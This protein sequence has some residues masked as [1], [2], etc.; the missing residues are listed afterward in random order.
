[1][2]DRKDKLV[3]IDGN[4]IIHRAW[5][6][7]PQTMRNSKGELVNAVFGFASILLKVIKDLKPRYLAV[8]MDAPGKNFR[9][10]EFPEYKAQ[11]VKKPQEFYDQFD[12]IRQVV[13]AFGLPLF[14]QPGLEAD[15]LIGSLVANPAARGLERIVVTGDQDALQLVAPGVSVYALRQGIADTVTYDAAAVREKFGLNPEQLVDY[16][17][18]RGDPSDN[19]PGVPGIGEK[20]A[21]ALLQQFGSLEN[22]YQHVE[23]PA[24]PVRTRALLQEHR[25]KALLAKRLCKITT[26]APVKFHLNECEVGAYDPA[27]VIRLFSEL[28]FKSLIN[29][30]PASKHVADAQGALA[31]GNAQNDAPTKLL[32]GYRLVDDANKLDDVLSHIRRAPLIAVDTETSSLDPL[33][34][35]LVGISLAWAEGE[36]AFVLPKPELLAK[37]KPMLSDAGIPKTGHNLKFDLHS[38]ET[39]GL[40]LSGIAFDSMIASYL[41]NPGSRQHGLD[42]L[43]FSEFGF[44]MTQITDLIGSGAK[45]RSMTEVPLDQVVPY[46]CA[47]ADYSLRLFSRL[48]RELEN[49]NQLG[50]LEKIE[51]PLI[52]VLARMER[53]GIKLDTAFLKKMST[54]V[55]KQ[56]A[57][58]E[59]KIHDLAGVPFNIASPLQMKEVLF[60]KLKIST[61][62]L[63]RTK[64]GISTAAGELE[65]LADQHQIIPLIME[66]R[67]LSKLQSTYLEALPQL[68]S[69]RDQR[70]HTSFNQTIAATGRLSSSDPNLQNI[71]IRTP[72][73]SQI[74][75]AFIAE[76]GNVL[77]SAD[78]NQIELRIIASLAQDPTMIS[79]FTRGE[80][81]HTRTAAEIHDVPV[82][83]VTKELRRTAKEVNFGIIYGMG[84]VG[85]SQRQGITRDKAKTFIDTYFR[86]HPKIAAYL[87]DTKRLA[88]E[89][90]FVETIFGR[91][92]YL[93]EIASSAP[94]IRSGAERAAINHPVQGTAADLM[95][96]AMIAV[97]DRLPAVCPAARMLLQVHD[98]LVFEVPASD[99]AALAR[100][101]K[102]T[103][104]GVYQLRVPILVHVE[105]GK[106]WGDLKPVDEIKGKQ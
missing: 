99:A 1:M 65:K 105:V 37:L 8:T 89:H 27:A 42:G 15:D 103:M 43:S 9:H 19:I 75:K 82:A 17:A 94:Q 46:A 35:D 96:L 47:D 100:F 70:L 85:L 80:D 59:S 31:L 61:V 90:G 45:Q 106:N 77:L 34:A 98:E 50:L 63:G 95:K 21:T 72:L 66:Y 26:D 79:A 62:G 30:L 92:R 67:E 6:A 48:H 55:G 10:H 38:L 3:I 5:H 36:A 16:K 102:K 13:A 4:A 22:L 39:A 60:G 81:V 7:L 33:T 49:K 23:D 78:Y 91:R 88:L 69:P 86:L 97:H 68:V 18:L 32:P 40:P 24:I 58:L 51:L 54:T 104:E 71:P 2:S 11:R 41:L 57:K 29:R 12:R 56:L 74:R 76:R 44:Q 28:E 52:Q 20:T 14:E 64:T 53:H 83:Q 101:V 73:G 84:V 87:E 93:P 25:E